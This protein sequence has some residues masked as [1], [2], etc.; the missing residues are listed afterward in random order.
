LYCVTGTDVTAGLSQN[1]TQPLGESGLAA[2]NG[3]KKVL[4]AAESSIGAI[5]TP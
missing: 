5:M 3:A 4:T 2:L 1:K